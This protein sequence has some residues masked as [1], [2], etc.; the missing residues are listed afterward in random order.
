VQVWLLRDGRGIDPATG[1]QSA[2]PDD[3]KTSS[4]TTACAPRLDAALAGLK[5]LADEAL[6]REALK[7]L[8]AETDEAR[9]PLIEKAL[10]GERVDGL[11]EQLTRCAPAFCWA[12]ASAP[13]ASRPRACWAKAT[14]PAPRPCWWSV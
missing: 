3:A 13:A 4:T 5:L 10:A 12:A 8:E 1:V 7:T 11:K 14:T 6:R 9:L 2:V